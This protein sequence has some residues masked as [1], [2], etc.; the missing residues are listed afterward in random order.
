MSL[1]S[2]DAEAAAVAKT[3]AEMAVMWSVKHVTK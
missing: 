1:Q 2:A 3:N